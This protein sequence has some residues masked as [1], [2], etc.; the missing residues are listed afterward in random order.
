[1]PVKAVVFM[2]CKEVDVFL[3]EFYRKHMSPNVKVHAT[4]SESGLIFNF[5]EWK[6]PFMHADQLNECLYSIKDSGF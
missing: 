1:M 2:V 4:V 5:N 6:F 3:D